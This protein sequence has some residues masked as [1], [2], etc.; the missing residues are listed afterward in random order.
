MAVQITQ[1]S[2]YSLEYG[3]F[4]YF[5]HPVQV[6]YLNFQPVG[7]DAFSVTYE[8]SADSSASITFFGTG[9]TYDVGGAPTGGTLEQVDFDYGGTTLA[10]VSGLSDDFD[11]DLADFLRY[12]FFEDDWTGFTEQSTFTEFLRYWASD[13]LVDIDV[14]MSVDSVTFDNESQ[15]VRTYLAT[16]GGDYLAFTSLPQFIDAG[17]GADYVAPG[18][19]G[20]VVMLGLNDGDFD[21]V[22]GDL[23]DLRGLTVL[24]FGLEDRFEIDTS[25]GYLEGVEFADGAL[26]LDAYTYSFGPEV[27]AVAM[28]DVPA[29]R[30]F[31]EARSNAGTV[32]Y[33]AENRGDIVVRQLLGDSTGDLFDSAVAG[34]FG[35]PQV[36]SPGLIHWG[37]TD[38]YGVD[39]V[40]EAVRGAG[41]GE[42]TSL[43]YFRDAVELFSITGDM[44]LWEI[45]RDF[46]QSGGAQHLNQPLAF[47]NNYHVTYDL[48]AADGAS[49]DRSESL[50][51]VTVIDGPGANSLQL[52]GGAVDGA[53]VE[54]ALDEGDDAPDF[55]EGAHAG[56]DGAVISGFGAGDVLSFLSESID[57]YDYA[58]GVLT[59][60]GYDYETGGTAWTTITFAGTDPEALPYFDDQGS[61]L[62][63]MLVPFRGG[64]TIGQH[65]PGN[66]ENDVLRPAIAALGEG[67]LAPALSG[68]G[69]QIYE[70]YGT[71]LGNL[72][73]RLSGENLDS[74]AVE[75][76]Q[77]FVNGTLW[78]SFEGALDQDV[79]LDALLSGDIDS[80][81]F[82]FVAQYEVT[83]DASD[84][85][86][87]E[88][89][90][91]SLPRPTTFIGSAGGD[92]ID[93]AAQIY[94]L[95]YQPEVGDI[96][97]AGAG[98]DFITAGAGD[99][100]DPGT[101][102]DY[103]WIEYVRGDLTIDLAAGAGTNSWYD[104]SRSFRDIYGIGDYPYARGPISMIIGTETGAI[105]Y[106]DDWNQTFSTVALLNAGDA[107]GGLGLWGSEDDDV[108]E[109]SLEADD[110]VQFLSEGG[111]DVYTGGLQTD[112]IRMREAGTRFTIT[113]YDETGASGYGL[114]GLGNR[115]DFTGVDQFRGSRNFS[116]AFFGGAGD[117][118]FIGEGGGDLYI[119]G[120]GFDLVNYN[121]S[122]VESVLVDLSLGV[123]HVLAA[124]G[125]DYGYVEDFAAIDM[126]YG[127]EGIQG[128]SGDDVIIGSA[129]DEELFGRAGDDIIDAGA[130]AD[131][132][133]GDSG[134]DVISLGEYEI[135][136]AGFGA[137]YAAPV[138]AGFSD[139]DADVVS[140]SIRYLD[141]DTILEFGIE[142]RIFVEGALL[143]NGD[144][145]WDG[146]TLTITDGVDSASV[147]VSSYDLADKTVALTRTAEGTEIAFV[148]ARAIG[149]VKQITVGD[150][151]QSLTFDNAY[152]D[153]VVFALG[154]SLNES[155]A[156]V[157]RLRNITGTG[158]EIFIQETKLLFD[159][160]RNDK[161]HVDETVTLLVLEKGV[162][163][164]DD[165]T[166]LEVGELRTNKLYNKGFESIAFEADFDATPTILSQV[167]SF[168]GSDFVLA[169][170][171]NASADG[172]QMT[173]QEEDADN[174]NHGYEDVGYLAIETGSGS[175][176]GLDFAAGHSP[177]NVNGNLTKV[178]MGVSLGDAP[179][180]LATI[181]SYNGTDPASAR[182]GTIWHNAFQAV[183][184]ED[185]SRDEET[186][187][188][189]EVI[190][191]LAFDGEG[192]LTVAGAAPVAGAEFAA[193]V[194]G[195]AAEG[196]P[197]E[198][199]FATGTATANGNEVTVEFGE[200]FDDPVV[201]AFLN[202]FNGRAMALAA[203]S[204]VGATSFTLSVAEDASD[205]GI[206]AWEEIS[207]LVVE[208]GTWELED[209]TILQAGT[210]GA[211]AVA[212][213]VFLSDAF[214]ATPAVLAQSQQGGFARALVDG[215]SADGFS[216][217]HAGAEGEDSGI[218]ALGW[219]AIEAGTATDGAGALLLEAGFAA[220]GSGF[221]GV[222]FAGDFGADA[223]ELF[224][225]MTSWDG[226][227]PAGARVRGLDADG[228]DIRVD[229]DMVADGE[230][231]HGI[232]DLSWLA[233]AD[234]AEG[235]G[236]AV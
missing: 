155:E 210:H 30:L 225:A 33:A 158:A 139:G 182:I 213:P 108:V 122:A 135:D 131:L 189:F 93:T 190:D 61:T 187:H 181:A 78:L 134:A 67:G 165:G 205:D 183:A 236:W 179:N 126:L 110:F 152:V 89:A 94:D 25:A 201:F 142:D 194:S 59:I 20:D 220:A 65:V 105:T 198:K 72:T 156:V 10:R 107:D 74:G 153:P 137:A 176:S 209:G 36:F 40:L 44:Q 69:E 17:A 167:Q 13:L 23:L 216:L 211:G 83:F 46:F 54:V 159:G 193:A 115:V 113:G 86:F 177:Q 197:A 99:W 199:V 202:S 14:S 91:I 223:P 47:L 124:V 174:V 79:L 203:V 170:Q 76:M 188:G 173:M 43:R 192:T 18:G 32:I 123:A 8:S 160:T 229:E 26:L 27:I 120:A 16:P 151:W 81:A 130:G 112:R 58:D 70:I 11:A 63:F 185:Q 75:L 200:G 96:V 38:A 235:Y 138:V 82:E 141:G 129:A 215:V 180:V 161:V 162:W 6:I 2:Q 50:F 35:A 144:V 219:L 52:Y 7:G 68:V 21:V 60:S 71:T 178:N 233:I 166:V 127:I 125:D 22:A 157:T 207:W 87:T 48:S 146:M 208:A 49:F 171:N 145:S 92:T 143:E 227:D 222:D 62:E 88:I 224:A 103:D 106:W 42:I 114:D 136:V 100:I 9:F 64:L 230:R 196:L 172:F 195:E 191:W 175:W 24:E 84:A 34:L 3:I 218:A 150:S 118:V 121:R 128:A 217:I 204:E 154:V 28:P 164:L 148:E 15:Y 1:F 51:G 101:N 186:T 117:E 31:F 39:H 4:A 55:I 168:D 214:D 73:V 37:A 102:D 140:N 147:S 80:D 12:A 97:H 234:G 56:L 41:T 45:E 232:E 111:H 231:D 5:V 77:I 85:G 132:V 163:T 104:I 98:S 133:S 149:E 119:G 90:D 184:F 19:G 116:D 221:A 53:P 206:H 212:S 29:G 95:D 228:F 57:Y 109:V 169:R 226:T 66:L